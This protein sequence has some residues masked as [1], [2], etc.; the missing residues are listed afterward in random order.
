[1]GK[2]ADRSEAL[3]K[4][5]LSLDF[6][7]GFDFLNL[8]DKLDDF[9]PALD[10][11]ERV[12]RISDELVSEDQDTVDLAVDLQVVPGDVISAEELLSLELVVQHGQDSVIELTQVSVD[13]FLSRLW[14]QVKLLHQKHGAD[15]LGDGTD[16]LV[17][18]GEK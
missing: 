8:G 4:Q 5:V 3:F 6:K 7:L 14:L 12:E 17:K 13:L 16:S 10:V 9:H 18:R 15:S 1:M 2:R 11:L